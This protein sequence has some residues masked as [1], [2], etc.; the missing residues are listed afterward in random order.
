MFE[1]LWEAALQKVLAKM[2][3]RLIELGLSLDGK[4]RLT[5]ELDADFRTEFDELKDEPVEVS[6]KKHRKKRS[7][8]ANAYA[9]VLIDKIAEKRGLTKTEVYRQAIKEVGGVSEF[10]CVQNKA[11]RALEQIW[12][13]KGL[14]WQVDEMESKIPGCTTLVLYMGSSEYDTKQMSALIDSLVQDAHSIGI[15]TK[16][17]EEINS[18]L[19]QYERNKKC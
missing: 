6:V 1:S 18:L 3:G 9:W 7:L 4:Q 14:G 16:T 5:V 8:D 12:T 15:T 17:D 19:E 11:V 2:T 10:C 13:N